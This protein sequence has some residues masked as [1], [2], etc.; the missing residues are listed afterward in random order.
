MLC[1][2]FN[3]QSDI[4]HVSLLYHLN[5]SNKGNNA[6]KNILQ[7]FRKRKKEEKQVRAGY[8]K[9]GLMSLAE[10]RSSV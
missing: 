8:W 6:I 7:H 10:S 1:A 3:G 9:H 2:K 5:I 4:L